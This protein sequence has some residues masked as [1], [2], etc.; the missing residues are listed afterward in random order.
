M[1]HTH[2]PKRKSIWSHLVSPH[3]CSTFWRENVDLIRYY[4]S[5]FVD[6]YNKKFKSTRHPKNSS[7]ILDKPW[8]RNHLW[9]LALLILFRITFTWC[10]EVFNTA[11][12]W[13]ESRD[14]LGYWSR[15]R[16]ILVWDKTWSEKR[17]QLI[18][19]L[20]ISCISHVVLCF[21]WWFMNHGNCW[22]SLYLAPFLG[23]LQ[24]LLHL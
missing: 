14:G 13:K 15:W 6:K 4:V 22:K 20:G 5:V 1:I 8:H 21:V 10:F 17:Q 11:C 12:R 19:R 2:L 18:Q 16:S 3:S 24:S 9:S 7:L 23:Q